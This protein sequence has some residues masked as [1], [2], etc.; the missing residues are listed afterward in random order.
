LQ[1]VPV[2]AVADISARAD[3]SASRASAHAILL[4]RLLIAHPI[5]NLIFLL[6]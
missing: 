4:S 6:A 2:G 3:I 5:T 1:P